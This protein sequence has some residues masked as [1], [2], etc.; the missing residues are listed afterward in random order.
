MAIARFNAADWPAAQEDIV[1][2]TR[3]VLSRMMQYIGQQAQ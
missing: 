1:N 2:T 3:D